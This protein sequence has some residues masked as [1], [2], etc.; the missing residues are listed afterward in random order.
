[1]TSI[2]DKLASSVRQAKSATPSKS[3]APRVAAGGAKQTKT[4]A[5][6]ARPATIPARNQGTAA[7]LEPASSTHVLFP[8]RV[9]PD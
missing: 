2:K 1:M 9:W 7:N 5:E 6:L 3:A 4:Q 8:D